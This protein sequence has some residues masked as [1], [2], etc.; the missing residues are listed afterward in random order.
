MKVLSIFAAV[1][2]LAPATAFAVH[3]SHCC[4]NIMCCL[5]HLGCC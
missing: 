3:V 4:G 1:G 2:A 5:K